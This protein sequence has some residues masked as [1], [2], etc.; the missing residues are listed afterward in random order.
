M[1]AGILSVNITIADK[2]NRLELLR[3]VN[4]SFSGL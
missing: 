4:Y 1:H 2:G 3:V